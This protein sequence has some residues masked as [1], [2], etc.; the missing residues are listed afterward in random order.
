MTNDVA[1]AGDP[2]SAVPGRRRPRLRGAPARVVMAIIVVITLAL[3]VGSLIAGGAEDAHTTG[4]AVVD[5]GTGKVVYERRMEVGETFE[6]RHTHSVTGREVV[7]TFSVLDEATLAIEELRF[8]EHGPNLPAGPQHVGAH[9]TYETDGDLVR[10]R[11]HGHPIGTLPLMIGSEGVDHTVIFED[12]AR[13]RLLDEVR[14][15]SRVE[16]VLEGDDGA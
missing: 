8:D 5:H 15:G 4:L 6:L 10:V 2:L 14:R 9:A 16:L 12:G 3:G 1:Q 11:H 13:L 7:E